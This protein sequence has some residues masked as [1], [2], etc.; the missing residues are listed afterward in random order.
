VDIG[1]LCDIGL[2]KRSDTNVI[3]GINP[4]KSSSARFK[5][6]RYYG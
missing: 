2:L 6:F 1:A 3:T 5:H 4:C